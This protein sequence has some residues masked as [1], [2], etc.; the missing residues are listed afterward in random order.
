MKIS[1]RQ[2]LLGGTATAAIAGI[3]GIRVFTGEIEPFIAGFVRHALPETRFAEGSA[4][5]FAKDYLAKT[6]VEQ[7]KIDQLMRAQRIVGYD[8]L[9]LLFGGNLSYEGFKRRVA[10]MFM[11]GS[12]FFSLDG[13][14]DPVR[15]VGTADICGNPFAR[16]T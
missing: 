14:Q 9:D 8:G 13:S 2:M 7:S 10:T 16:L 4:E 12:D 1:R 11:L 5:D 15:Y 3:G 6:E